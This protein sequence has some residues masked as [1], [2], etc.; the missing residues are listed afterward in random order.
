MGKLKNPQKNQGTKIKV[1]P[2]DIPAFSDIQHPIFCFKNLHK[3][4]SL[5]Q[6]DN[7]ELVGLIRKLCSLS[8][9]TW[10]NIQFSAKHA[11]GSEKIARNSIKPS[12]PNNITEDVEHFL[13]IRFLGKKCFIG[14]RNHFIFHIVYIDRDFTVYNHG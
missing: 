6:C 11:T 4:H 12:I 5:D 8:L 13:S 9:M 2:N 10:Q 3:N 14:Y 1:T 7:D